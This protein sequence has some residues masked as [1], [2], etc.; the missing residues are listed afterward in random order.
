M[1]GFGDGCVEMAVC[2]FALEEE[3]TMQIHREPYEVFVLLEHICPQNNCHVYTVQQ[4]KGPIQ[5]PTAVTVEAGRI[6]RS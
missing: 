3:H 1:K 2:S 5:S 6:T 4:V